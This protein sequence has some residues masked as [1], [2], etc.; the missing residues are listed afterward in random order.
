MVFMATIF[1]LFLIYS[2]MGW[3][4]EV[5]DL[6]IEQGK[7]VDRGFL[8]G[9]ICPIYG[10]SSILIIALLKR[11]VNDPFAFFVIACLICAVVE[12]LTSFL[13]EK[14]FK[15][16]W[17]DYSDKKFNIN[18]RICLGTV[19]IFGILCTIMMYYINPFFC[20]LLESIPDNILNIIAAILAVAF[21]IDIAIS[22]NIIFN[23]KKITRNVRKDSTEEIKKAIRHFINKNI[24]LHKRLVNAF[25]DIRRIIIEKKNSLKNSL[26][27]K[28]K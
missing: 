27:S 21:T 12:Y 17:W 4:L 7:W 9:P 19:A 23:L 20:N 14:L 6:R 13:F 22:F 26:K 16:R 10:V 25:P 15:L 24:T 8:I 18:G 5:L 11:Y 3:I 2:F 1:L 28:K